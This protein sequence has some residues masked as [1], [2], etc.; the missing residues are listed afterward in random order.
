MPKTL[1]TNPLYFEKVAKT[2]N[3]NMH[4]QYEVFRKVLELID[5]QPIATITDIGCGTGIITK[6][7]H[8]HFNCSKT[9]GLDQSEAMI[10][11]AK[12]NFQ[13][14]SENILFKQKTAYEFSKEDQAELIFSNA[15]LQWLP[16]LDLFFKTLKNSIT[17]PTTIAFSIFLPTTYHELAKGLKH[18]IN[19]SISIPAEQFKSYDD[20][21]K[22]CSHYF[23][24][25]TLQKHK[26][27]HTYPSIYELL[28][29]IK[30]TGT[31]ELYPQ[32]KF[33]QKTLRTL[34]EWL[35]SNYDKIPAS[36]EIAI[37]KITTN[38]IK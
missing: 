2:Y 34:E 16:D 5:S 12:S 25:I 30:L 22:T 29:I 37:G 20:I 19:K 27:I 17:T 13:S 15:T 8:D 6:K 10:N 11:H 32:I 4:I 23:Q 24:D 3:K 21:K 7:L 18:I 38:E 31:K 14:E 9:L 35:L 1:S 33:T 36:Y 26:I 28:N